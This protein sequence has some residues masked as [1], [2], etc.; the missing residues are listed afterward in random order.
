MIF[1]ELRSSPPLLAFLLVLFCSCWH[2][3]TSV[4]CA[5]PVSDMSV[6]RG[7]DGMDYQNFLWR[8]LRAFTDVRLYGLY[9]FDCEFLGLARSLI[10]RGLAEGYISGSEFLRLNRLLHSA[11]VYS[12]DLR[13]PDARNAGPYMPTSVW[14]K[15]HNAKAGA[16]VVKL[17]AQG[18]A[19][20]KPETVPAPT[21][22]PGLRLLCLLD[23]TGSADSAKPVAT[24]HQMPPRPGING[25]WPSACRAPLVL[26]D[27]QARCPTAEVLA[28]CVRHR[29]TNAFRTAARTI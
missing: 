1:S 21:S 9:R 18:S 8:L 15:R 14:F 7:H 19:N 4:M 29:Q 2:V 10:D 13:F 24:L 23:E 26:R 11:A 12:G 27:T 5:L 3:V 28:R 25:Q 22:R 20:E 17:G 16:I 6:L